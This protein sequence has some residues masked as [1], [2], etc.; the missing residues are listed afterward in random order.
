MRA[1]RDVSMAALPGYAALLEAKGHTVKLLT[2]TGKEMLAIRRKS[3]KFIFLQQQK[4]GHIPKDAVFNPAD[5]RTD[6]IDE[7]G[8]YYSG[9]M[10][11][12]SV[13]G[14]L[15]ERGR[16]TACADASHCEGIGEQS[17]GTLYEIDHYDA[18]N[19]LLPAV[20]G[21]YIGTED[22]ISWQAAFDILHPSFDC[23]DRV[24]M[25][26]NEKSIDHA[27]RKMEFARPFA[28]ERH[29]HK[30]MSKAIGSEKGGPQAVLVG[31]ARAV[32]GAR[33]EHYGALRPEADGLPVE[34]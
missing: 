17:F 25:V 13:A 29:I 19:F 14:A 31:P 9:V 15:A 12:P 10:F 22:L 8:T 21:H 32:A 33:V 30:N 23:Q 24:V 6:D 18:G 27:L 20:V 11:R 3:S 4:D 5:V 2:V 16:K 34:V 1:T 28:D 26:D 7:G